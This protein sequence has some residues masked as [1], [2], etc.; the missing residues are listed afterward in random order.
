MPVHEFLPPIKGEFKSSWPK[1]SPLIIKIKYIINNWLF[2]NLRLFFTKD[3][4]RRQ[5]D[6]GGRLMSINNLPASAKKRWESLDPTVKNLYLNGEVDSATI[7]IAI[8]R[9]NELQKAFDPNSIMYQ[10]GKNAMKKSLLEMK[11]FCLDNNVKFIVV[12]IPPSY[13]VS[14]KQ[15]NYIQD[16]GFFLDDKIIDSDILDTTAASVSA[17]LNIPFYS[18]TK[19]FR[20]A[21][22]D[23]YFY[24]DQHFTPKGHFKFAQTIGTFVL[25]NMKE[26]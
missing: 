10:N 8:H 3:V 15:L 6:S 20:N 26:K 7:S 14:S 5:S 24:Y 2:P 22:E 19:T 13:Y 11:Q 23:L 25:N 12:G 16:I 9:P 18:P 4:F 21:K 1:N 17:E